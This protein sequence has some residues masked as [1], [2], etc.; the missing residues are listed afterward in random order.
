M[1]ALQQ[2]GPFCPAWSMAAVGLRAFTPDACCPSHMPILHVHLRIARL[3]GRRSSS[4]TRTGSSV[5]NL[6]CGTLISRQHASTFLSTSDSLENRQQR[7]RTV[8]CMLGLPSPRSPRAGHA[9][10]R[11]KDSRLDHF[12]FTPELAPHTG[13]VLN[14]QRD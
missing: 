8:P 6:V 12:F 9:C 1:R 3:Q 7:S 10:L 14:Y 5:N 4:S 11:H 2:R 13:K